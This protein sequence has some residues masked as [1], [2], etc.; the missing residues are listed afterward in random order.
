MRLV[1]LLEAQGQ[2][3]YHLTSVDSANSIIQTRALKMMPVA[4]GVDIT[5]DSD[6]PHDA[7]SH[8]A[9]SLT[10]S[11]TSEFIDSMLSHNGVVLEFDSTVLSYHN[12]LRPH[13]DQAARE[14][15]G[16]SYNE[17]EER[18]YSS[19]PI[20]QL[21]GA[22]NKVIT[23]VHI[24]DMSDPTVLQRAPQ[25][26]RGLFSPYALKM[27]EATCEKAGVVVHKYRSPNELRQL[28]R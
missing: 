23:G 21:R 22:I 5:K 15:M 20:V 2:T 28:G 4:N 7:P 25:H 3:L 6:V 16:N 19:Q 27:L 9:F 18:L 12:K 1:H 14:E 17:M 11:M 8:Y 26:S 24:V 13:V 10:R